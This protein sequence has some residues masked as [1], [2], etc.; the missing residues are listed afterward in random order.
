MLLQGYSMLAQG[1]LTGIIAPESVTLG[2]LAPFS[3]CLFLPHYSSPYSLLLLFFTLL[4][5]HSRLTLRLLSRYYLLSSGFCGCYS[6]VARPLLRGPSPYSGVSI[7]P[8]SPLILRL[9]GRYSELS[10]STPVTAPPG[11]RDY[12]LP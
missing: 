4:L 9:L 3:V 12:S 6:E 8:G 5:P 1:H 2:I 11:P 10:P 7:T